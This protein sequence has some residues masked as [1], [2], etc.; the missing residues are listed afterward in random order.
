[1][2]VR[3]NALRVRAEEATGPGPADPGLEGGLL[4]PAERLAKVMREG[5]E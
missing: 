3:L 1:M 2:N 4:L 5:I